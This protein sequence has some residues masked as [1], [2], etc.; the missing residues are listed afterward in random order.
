MSLV[1]VFSLFI[2]G[3]G[4]V[5]EIV[6]QAL[7]TN[8]IGVSG[9]G[10]YSFYINMMEIIFWVMFS[11]IVKVNTFYLSEPNSSITDFKNRFYKRY[12]FPAVLIGII[13][14]GILH[15]PHVPFILAI[16]VLHVRVFDESSTLMARGQYYH[17]L[18]GEYSLGRICLLIGILVLRFLDK[19]SIAALLVLYSVQY[20]LILL[21]FY[22]FRD[23]KRV[24]AQGSQKIVDKG[25][26]VRFQI[27]DCTAGIVTQVP[28]ILQHFVVG[29][30]EAGFVSIVVL[31]RRLVNFITGPTAKIFMPEF[32]RLYHAG[33]QDG[34]KRYYQLIMRIQMAFISLLCIPMVGF[35]ELILSV[36]SSELI[37]YKAIF[38]MVSV[39]FLFQ[40]TLGPATSLLQ[41]TD[42]EQVDNII[43]GMSIV[44]MMGVWWFFRSDP[45]FTL[46]GLCAQALFESLVKYFVCIRWMGGPPVK[47]LSYIK[48][49]I[50]DL[51]I[52]IM[53][54][55]LQIKKSFFS[56]FAFEFLVFVLTLALE[57]TNQDSR[58]WA[59]H[60]L[61]RY[62]C[63]HR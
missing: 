33:D 58:G 27:S 63:R 35:P 42:R 2:K 49:W 40:A 24:I 37:Q 46:Y 62:T 13:G 26:I 54:S 9:Y 28:V 10:D 39:V 1:L 50:P 34:L 59:F 43:K 53:I 20:A 7:I 25:K 6:N 45:V 61:E 22:F 16:L 52:L 31:V 12:L 41:M 29:P 11:S 32:S 44:V 56:L 55:T 17:A 3:V 30:F 47:I 57:M 23:R 21:D 18:I 48:M 19:M 4:A 36:F 38:Q 8:T 5:L 14:T 15:I 51:A 60:F